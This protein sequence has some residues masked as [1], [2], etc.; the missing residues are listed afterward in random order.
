MTSNSSW[1]L[2]SRPARPEGPV[3]PT[4]SSSLRNRTSSP[5]WKSSM[6]SVMS[7]GGEA[8][9]ISVDGVPC[10]A[11]VLGTTPR[12]LVTTPG[13]ICTHPGVLGTRLAVVGTTARPLGF[14]MGVFDTHPGVVATT[15][16]CPGSTPRVL[17]TPLGVLG[18]SS[19]ASP[20]PWMTKRSTMKVLVKPPASPELEL[21]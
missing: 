7:L 12:P 11:G 15:V 3:P 14:A 9:S 5:S 8:N 20:P 1:S 2:S 4:M 18:T 16:G 6:K 13:V 10:S 19:P 21:F 17:S